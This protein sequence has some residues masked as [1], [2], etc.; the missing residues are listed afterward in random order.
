ML[1]PQQDRNQLLMISLESVVGE[2]SIVRVVDAFVDSLDLESLGFIIK[3]NIHNGAPAFR[4]SNLLKLYY[5]GYLHKVPSSRRLQ[6]EARTNYEAIWLMR[7]SR[8]GY[9]TIADFR[10]DNPVALKKVFT[11]L[12]KFLKGQDLFDEENAAVD[13]SKFR[14][15]NSKKNNY[16]EKKVTQHLD[17]IERKTQEYFNEMDELDKTEEE[18][19]SEWEQRIE[20][21]EKLDAL[22][23]RKKKYTQLKEQVEQAREK[24]QTQVSTVDGDARALPKKMNIVEVGYNV[25]AAAEL[26]NKLITNFKVTNESDTYALSEVAMEARTVLEKQ[27]GE[28]LTVLADKGFDTGSELKKCAENDIITMVAPKKRVHPKKEK[29]FNKDAFEY[30]EEQDIYICPEN[31]SLTSNGTWYKKNNGKHR[32]AYK[33]KHYKLPFAICNACPHRLNCAGK[34]NLKNSKGRYIERSEY[35][36]YIEENIERVKL[37]KELYRKRQETIEHQ[38][39]TIKRVWGYDH[40]LLKGK[41]KVTG[42]FAI[43]FTCYNLRRAMSLLGV[44]ELVKRI[45]TAFSFVKTLFALILSRLVPFFKIN[46]NNEFLFFK[47]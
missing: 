28:K 46:F 34:A 35:Q 37:N 12:N 47:N 36:P 5:Y 31:H 11:Q 7:G 6:R 43:I 16:N 1:K 29:A 13:G 14:A 41:E 38:F 10:K 40:T 8:P 9:K 42:E 39:G 44:S 26:K 21:C 3:G 23:E 18:T 32:R 45:E 15:Q 25:V 22:E 17:Y 4:A 2:D 30:D 27:P 33:V 19:E 20:L 24:G